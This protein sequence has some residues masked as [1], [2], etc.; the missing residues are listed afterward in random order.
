MPASSLSV[1]EQFYGQAVDTELLRVI[2]GTPPEQL[3]ELAGRICDVTKE[4]RTRISATASITREHAFLPEDIYFEAW[5]DY[6]LVDAPNLKHLILYCK[7]LLV[8]DPL[9]DWAQRAYG[10]LDWYHLGGVMT[11]EESADIARQAAW[12]ARELAPLRELII[13]GHIRLIP[14][15][16]SYEFL[17]E[18]LSVYYSLQ[19]EDEYNLPNLLGRDYFLE[20]IVTDHLGLAEK[21]M[22]IDRPLLR[23]D[24]RGSALSPAGIDEIAQHLYRDRGIPTDTLLNQVVTAYESLGF[25]W[26]NVERVAQFSRLI[27]DLTAVPITADR[28]TRSRL[29]R[30]TRLFMG[31]GGSD[32]ISTAGDSS[33]QVPINYKIPSAAGVS[34][35]D[36]VRLRQDESLYEDVRVSLTKLA[37]AVEDI[38][39]MGTFTEYQAVV[40]DMADDL[41]RPTFDKLAS[42]LQRVGWASKVAGLVGGAVVRLGFGGLLTPILGPHVATSAGN[43][44]G[45]ASQSVIEKRIKR[46]Q[47][48]RETARKLLVSVLDDEL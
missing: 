6:S 34:L 43:T 37:R 33:L 36:V 29:V 3:H 32:V 17:D 20:W 7:S 39:R 30:E 35:E 21:H 46:H 22:E 47:P 28:D 31:E 12:A 26:D 15:A 18:P 44:A 41:V 25:S 38:G 48:E 23:D 1:L 11:D 8:P 16:N 10:E 4:G 2:R 9:G 27:L 42:T 19:E 13:K 14:S 24:T 5:R 40:R 45:N